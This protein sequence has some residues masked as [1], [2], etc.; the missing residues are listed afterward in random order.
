MTKTAKRVGWRIV[1][2]AFVA[3]VIYAILDTIVDNSLVGCRADAGNDCSTLLVYSVV[4]GVGLLVSV[5]LLSIALMKYDRSLQELPVTDTMYH[6]SAGLLTIRF[7]KSVVLSNRQRLMV[8]HPTSACAEDITATA[9]E[10]PMPAADAKADNRVLSFTV[11]SNARSQI[12]K[13]LKKSSN[14]SIGFAIYPGA[15]H[16]TRQ[17]D[18]TKY[19]DGNPILVTDIEI[20]HES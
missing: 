4:A 7:G 19:N 1:I 6:V 13:V 14:K 9:L 20:I 17:R 2:A 3:I 11:P 18:I 16:T 12:Q 15:I 10:A 5:A 8:T